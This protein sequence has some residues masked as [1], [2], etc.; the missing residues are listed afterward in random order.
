V[1]FGSNASVTGGF[2]QAD[3]TAAAAFQDAF[4]H[5][6]GGSDAGLP[7]QTID[8]GFFRWQ[9]VTAPTEA[10]AATLREGLALHGIAARELWQVFLRALA[11]PLPQ[12][13][14]STEDLPSVVAEVDA[15]SAGGLLAE[16]ARGPA[17][18][19]ERPDL[20]VA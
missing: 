14:V 7:V 17:A 12:V 16:M 5:A 4:A 2:G 8:W 18:S 11:S 10:L 13:V 15:F 1:L 9:A 6:E 3:T 19:H 20:A